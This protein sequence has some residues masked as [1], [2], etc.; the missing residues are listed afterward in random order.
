MNREAT[1]ANYVLDSVRKDLDFL[2]AQ[3]YLTPEAYNTIVS[4]L[5]SNSAPSPAGRAM[6]SPAPGSATAPSPAGGAA[7][8]PPSYQ[9]S[10]GLAKAEALYDFTGA[11]PQDLSFRRGDL[12]TV[13]EYGRCLLFPVSPIDQKIIKM[14]TIK[15]NDT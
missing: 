12:I 15:T 2:K 3:Q 6:P 7:P 11:N 8:P 14:L 9:A 13:T 10:T 5:P 1:F 4:N